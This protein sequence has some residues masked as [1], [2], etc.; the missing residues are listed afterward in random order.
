MS[1]RSDAARGVM[2]MST[3]SDAARGV[4]TMSTHSDAARGVVTDEINDKRKENRGTLRR[5]HWSR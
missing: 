5:D 2:T 1:T 3:R 4:V